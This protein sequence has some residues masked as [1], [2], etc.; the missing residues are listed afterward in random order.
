MADG[1]HPFTEFEIT[2]AS[3]PYLLDMKDAAVVLQS[4]LQKLNIRSVLKMAEPM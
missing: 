4:Q 2:V 3:T 1:R